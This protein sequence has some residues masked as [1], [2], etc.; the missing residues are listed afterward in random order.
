M[1]WMRAELPLMS[2]TLSAPRI[3]KV[4]DRAPGGERHARGAWL[5]AA[6]PCT[7][8]SGCRHEVSV[9]P[10]EYGRTMLAEAQR[11]LL[12]RIAAMWRV[13]WQPR[14]LVRQVRRS[15]NPRTVGLA[16]V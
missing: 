8:S 15:T 3:R 4:S 5:P 10:R 7:T 9:R 12:L 11:N 1:E 14:E 13:G 2:A 16:L 6:K